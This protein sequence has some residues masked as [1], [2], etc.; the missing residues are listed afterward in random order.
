MKADLMACV[1]IAVDEDG[2]LT[3][4]YAKFPQFPTLYHQGAGAAH[5]V[6]I[7]FDDGPDPKWTPQV[8]DILKANKRQSGIFPRRRE[9]GT[10]SRTR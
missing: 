3:A 6:A 5:Q 1:R 8:L 10:L 4:T 7:T 2:Y 9:C